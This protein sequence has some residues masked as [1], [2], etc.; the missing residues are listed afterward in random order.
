[1]LNNA[2]TVT[3]TLPN[4]QTGNSP[5]PAASFRT[6]SLVTVCISIRLTRSEG[7]LAD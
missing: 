5:T 7:T 2:G 4:I 1:M 6:L 3:F